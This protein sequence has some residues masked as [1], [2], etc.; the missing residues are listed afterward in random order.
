MEVYRIVRK[1]YA[2]GLNTSGAA[3]RW[4][5]KGQFVLYTGCSRLLATLEL[6]VHMGPATPKDSYQVMIIHIP[7]NDELYTQIRSRDL[8]ANWRGMAAYGLLQAMGSHWYNEQESLV[9]KV[10]SAVIPQEFNF[11]INTVH[12]LF[13]ANIKLVSYEEYFWDT[14]LG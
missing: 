9:L 8:P 13:A 10:P 3:N 2:T 1:K 5:L 11:V 7:D 4:N 14:R 6:V 12:P